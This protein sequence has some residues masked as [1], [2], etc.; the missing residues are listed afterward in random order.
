[1]A[2][3]KTAAIASP[4]DLTGL[5]SLGCHRIAARASRRFSAIWQVPSVFRATG[6]ELALN[7]LLRGK[8]DNA[9]EIYKGRYVFGSTAVE[10]RGQVI[11]DHIVPDVF[12]MESLHSFN[13]LGALEAGRR[14]LYRA[15]ARG[16]VTDW[17]ERS[18]QFGPAAWRVPV[19]S[20]RMICWAQQAPFLV[21]GASA[22]FERAF[23]SAVSRQV[24]RL[25]RKLGREHDPLVRMNGAIA[26]VYACLG[27]SGFEGLRQ[28]AYGRLAAELEQ[29]ILPDGG[30][31]SRNPA[32]L[33]CLLLD[34]VPLRRAL[35]DSHLEVPEELN[36]ALER[37]MPMLR[38]FCHDDGG[39][40]VFN[41]VTGTMAGAVRA[42]LDADTTLGRPLT[43]AIHSGYCRLAEG[44]SRVI[45]DAGYPPA[46]GLNAGAACDPLAFEF[47]DGAHRIVVNCGSPSGAAAEWVDAARMTAAHST[48]C[49]NDRSAG[50]I[51]SD[52]LTCGIFGTPVIVGPA[53]VRAKVIRA[54]GGG[55][56]DALHNG[57]FDEYG[58]IHQRRLFL[59]G[60]GTDLR[61]EDCFVTD[62][63]N[64][65]NLSNVPFAIRFHL[66]P[67]VKATVSMDAG[68][69]MLMLPN[70]TG[71]RF[72]A[73]GGRLKLEDSVYL[74]GGHGVRRTKQIV[75]EGV[76]GRPDRLQ[77]AFK[78]IAKRKAEPVSSPERAPQLPL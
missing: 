75:L 64:P 30:H 40:A 41:G 44:S 72:S 25:N 58:I 29:Q 21:Q 42:V 26:L 45:M 66:H 1:M 61:G 23:L 55:A 59:G 20:R 73:R 36:G 57:Y 43:H 67:S 24:R 22:Q 63:E 71:W 9:A 53:D 28:S 2:K 38:F 47:S 15:Q 19:V 49:L 18:G 50:L 10:C 60:N 8:S 70:K 35:Q 39:L 48:V 16:L 37:M 33:L 6:L 27:F 11:F 17:I 46:P 78:R 74:P 52:R 62:I 65:Q 68:S 56:V 5:I 54:E 51:L 7:P 31:I 12:W 13:W 32:T 4:V 3:T 77:W 69:V 34:L 76:T 14:Q